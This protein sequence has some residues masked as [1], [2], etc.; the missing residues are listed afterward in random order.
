MVVFLSI[1]KLLHIVYELFGII[2]L[3]SY[4]GVFSLLSFILHCI[5]AAVVLTITIMCNRQLFEKISIHD[6][7]KI[8]VSHRMKQISMSSP[9]HKGLFICQWHSMLNVNPYFLR[10]N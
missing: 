3:R 8:V 1:V 7:F 10:R 6:P 9:D 2:G 5:V 4:L